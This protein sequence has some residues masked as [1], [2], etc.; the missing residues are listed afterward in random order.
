MT[1]PITMT[2]ATAALL[3]RAGLDPDVYQAFALEAELS[4]GIDWEIQ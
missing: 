4:A 2:E 3:Q 1:H